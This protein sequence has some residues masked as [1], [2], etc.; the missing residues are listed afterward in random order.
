MSY[1]GVHSI[2]NGKICAYIRGADIFDLM[3]PYYS[4]PPLLKL[5]CETAGAIEARRLPGTA[6]WDYSLE[7]RSS[8]RDFA[9]ADRPVFIRALHAEQPVL[10]RLS[11]LTIHYLT[12]VP[13]SLLSGTPYVLGWC[14]FVPAGTFFYVNQRD[15]DGTAVQGYPIADRLFV[16]AAVSGDAHERSFSEDEAAF[17][18]SSGAIALICGKDETAAWAL[19]DGLRA[20]GPEGAEALYEE[21]GE[22]W[23][24][25]TQAR[26]GHF[27]A[28]HPIH[29]AIDEHD[30]RD[31]HDEVYE[32]AADDIAVLLKTQQDDSGGILA[33]CNYHL[34]YV[35]DNYGCFRGLLA[36]GCVAEAKKLL[37]Y[38]AG[39]HGQYG[40]VATAQGMGVYA[41]HNHEHDFAENTGY[42]VLMAM[43]Y[44][45]RTRDERFLQEL[46][47]L[48]RWA[49]SAQKEHLVDG[50][51]P[52]SGDETYIAG[53]VL[54][55]ANIQDGSM[56]ATALYHRAIELF[57]PEAGRL[58]LAD[59]AFIG[60]QEKARDEIASTFTRNFIEQ[61]ILYC[62]KPGL[63]TD[64]NA[65]RRRQGVME[66]GH[67]FG[68]SYRTATGRYV[69]IKCLDVNELQPV[70][71][72]R[73][74]ILST[75]FMP[76]WI[77][78]SL[79]PLPI[80]Q[81]MAN[82]IRQR[83][84]ETGLLPSRPDGNITVGYDY[85]LTIYAVSRLLPDDRKT[86]ESL[87][88]ACLDIRD[89]TGA[90]VEYYR[91][92]LPQGTPCRP[93]ES[94]VN[95]AALLDR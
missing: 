19:F 55:R 37:G 91:D 10:W 45:N 77:N 63:Y 90:W 48:L 9:A 50:M 60:E 40:R 46:A 58:G 84:N 92:G 7:G 42:L 32:K 31:E 69:C 6:V 57:L 22:Y 39:V 35:R 88:R 79:V 73:Y 83:W 82:E 95:I 89:S 74:N 80:L 62:N 87:H 30:E 1:A 67:G 52:F 34:A 25:F 41:F 24:S 49:L 44:F 28:A 78:S 38:Y 72:A 23:R 81:S 59:S 13:A 2:G 54:P 17:S 71:P 76:L 70:P 16:I 12:R 64:T 33:G 15:K 65:P 11:R 66:C 3:G 5:R 29:P 43:E 8:W 20:A 27:R 68:C 86:L 94:A 47:P 51:L 53:G 93:W 26:L 75:A 18:V 61:G 14:G 4:T 21:A 85:G 56:E 36:L